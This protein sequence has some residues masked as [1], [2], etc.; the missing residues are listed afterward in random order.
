MTK[1]METTE[2]SE[3]GE[4]GA[5]ERTAD[6]GEDVAQ[7]EPRAHGVRTRRLSTQPP[8]TGTPGPTPRGALGE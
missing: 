7:L 6:T 4:T 8:P 5:L 1:L 3:T 2:S